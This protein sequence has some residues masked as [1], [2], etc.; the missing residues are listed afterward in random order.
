VDAEVA[1][2]KVGSTLA[3]GKVESYDGTDRDGEGMETA[4]NGPFA[5]ACRPLDGELFLCELR[6]LFL[7][8]MPNSA[9][10]SQTLHLRK[11]RGSIPPSSIG[12]TLLII[13]DSREERW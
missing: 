12:M 3:I 5:F 7:S 11:N 4:T 8:S 6:G 13:S 2:Y 9:Q 10:P 1:E